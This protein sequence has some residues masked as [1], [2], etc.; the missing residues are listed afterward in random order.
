MLFKEQSQI[1]QFTEDLSWKSISSLANFGLIA[2]GKG[3]DVTNHM[4]AFEVTA[5]NRLKSLPA[6]ILLVRKRHLATTEF[7]RLG[8]Y[9]LSMERGAVIQMVMH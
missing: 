3:S 7:N 4:I 6:L 8:V 5:Y 9:N 2:E 1:P